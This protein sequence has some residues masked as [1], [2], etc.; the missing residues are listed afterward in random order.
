VEGMFML[1][2]AGLLGLYLSYVVVRWAAGVLRA[3]VSPGDEAFDLAH[4]G[5]G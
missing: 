3:V 2:M 5:R 1:S 4:G